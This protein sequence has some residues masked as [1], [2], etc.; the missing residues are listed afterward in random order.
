[1]LHL[2]NNHSISEV[3]KSARWRNESEKAFQDREQEAD[4]FLLGVR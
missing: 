1:M 3:S 4:F 2:Y